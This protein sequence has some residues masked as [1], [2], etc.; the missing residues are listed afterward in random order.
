MTHE[1]GNFRTGTMLLKPTAC[2]AMNSI[3]I[4]NRTRT[5]NPTKSLSENLTIHVDANESTGLCNITTCTGRDNPEPS[6]PYPFVSIEYSNSILCTTES[7]RIISTV[8]PLDPR[9]RASN[10]MA[11]RTVNHE[12]IRKNVFVPIIENTPVDDQSNSSRPFIP[13]RIRN[14]TEEDFINTDLFP[15]RLLLPDDF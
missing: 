6:T 10:V 7:S 5:N 13:P 2:L 8:S 14:R 9:E 4:N 11:P 12:F 1:T 3:S 15:S